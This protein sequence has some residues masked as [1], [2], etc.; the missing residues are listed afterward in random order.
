MVTLTEQA[1]NAARRFLKA[2]ES[3]A[4]GLRIIISSLCGNAFQCGVRLEDHAEPNDA[5]VDC[6]TVKLFIDP[7]SAPLIEGATID[8]IDDRDVSGF[9]FTNLGAKSN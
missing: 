3:E 8:F 4:T 5:I 1:I 2:S 7:K 6:G 9:R